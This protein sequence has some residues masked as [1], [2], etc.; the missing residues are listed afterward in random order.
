MA[1]YDPAS[2]G[3]GAE[4][5]LHVALGVGFGFMLE[6]AGFGSS[7]KLTSQFFLNDLSV[8]KVMF[9]A[10]ITAMLLVFWAS[11]LGLLDFAEL[12]VN[13]TYLG[14]GILGGL[15]FG[16]GFVVG[17]YCPGTALVAAAT[18][19]LDGMFFAAGLLFG[20]LGFGY[21]LPWIDRFWNDSGAFGRLTLYEWLDLSPGVVV[22]LAVAMALGMFFAAERIEV[23]MRARAAKG[24]AP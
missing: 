12:W 10:I 9:T 21:T 14:S 7:R 23:W 17:G 20:I 24:G 13:P 19:K 3:P 22:L 11:G 18:L 5:L 1:P 2:W 8:L 15:L 4:P 16:V 6:R